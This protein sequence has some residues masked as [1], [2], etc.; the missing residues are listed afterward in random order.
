M[1]WTSIDRRADGSWEIS[2]SNGQTLSSKVLVGA[3]GANSRIRQRLAIEVDRSDYK[4]QAI[5]AK[6]RSEKPHQSTAYQRFLGEGPVAF[7]PLAQENE[8]S[9]VWTVSTEKSQQLLALSE[10]DFN[11]ALT[12]RFD[13]RLGGLELASNR[14]H[15][16]LRTHQAKEYTRPG[17]FLIGDAAHGVHPLAGQGVNLGFHDVRVLG[18]I[19][20]E[21]E[22][23]KRPLLTDSNFKKYER[24][25]FWYNETIRQ[26]MTLI[27]RLFLNQES[28]AICSKIR[29]SGMDFIDRFGI[30]KKL[31]S[32]VAQ[33]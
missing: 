7:L 32:Q 3:D 2:L 9:L 6:I 23:L 12:A 30:V 4:Q 24:Q 11:D 1:S 21:A 5:V 28:G 17:A 16:P 20:R 31:F 29:G 14:L 33:G 8:G 10:K 19:L 25:A 22:A 26:S 13:H 27:N 18:Q 15:F